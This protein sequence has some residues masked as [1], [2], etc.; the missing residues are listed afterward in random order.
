MIQTVDILMFLGIVLKTTSFP[1]G[2][3][4]Y[5]LNVKIQ[6]AAEIRENLMKR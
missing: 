1:E 5:Y 6:S 4:K 2:N 3:M